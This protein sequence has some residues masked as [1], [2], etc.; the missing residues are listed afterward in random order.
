MRAELMPFG[1]EWREELTRMARGSMISNQAATAERSRIWQNLRFRSLTETRIV[2]ALDRASVLFFSLHG[3]LSSTDEL[4]I[5]K[6]SNQNVPSAI[7]C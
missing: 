1:P 2:E 4:L 3:S 6:N 7:L 5:E